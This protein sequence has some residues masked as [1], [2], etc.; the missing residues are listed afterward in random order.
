[1]ILK[2]PVLP[3]LSLALLLAAPL[4]GQQV[5]ELYVFPDTMRLDPGGRGGLTVQ[6]FDQS[7]NAVLA[8]RYR[9]LD[10]LVAR[11]A[12]TGVVTGGNRGSTRVVVEAGSRTRAV[13]VVVAPPSDVPVTSAS[14]PEPGSGSTGPIPAAVGLNRRRLSLSPG[15]R[16]TLVLVALEESNRR[17]AP[18]LAVWSSTDGQVVEVDAA[19]AVSALAVGRAEVVVGVGTTQL[20]VPV[21]V[22]QPVAWFGVSPALDDTVQ[23]PLGTSRE[24]TVLP[25]TADS[26]PI[27]GVSL[28]WSVGDT[29][30]A[31]L[32]PA[33][34]Q[35][36]GLSPGRT[37]LAFQAQ[38]FLAKR[39]NIKVLSGKIAIAVGRVTLSPG[40]RDT[41]RAEH[42]D[43]A[44]RRM[45]RA[46][47]V[48]SSS[49][50][51]VARVSPA[52]VLEA[53]GPGRGQVTARTLSGAAA[54]ATVVVT[55]DLLVAFNRGGR[56]ALYALV[57][58]R[59][60]HPAPVVADSFANALDG[61][62]S[63]DRT[64]LAFS[65]DR[66]GAGN[67]D[68]FLADADGHN[69][70]RLTTDP[71]VDA[72]AVWVPDGRRL[73]YVSR[74]GAIRQLYVVETDGSGIRQLTSLPG[75]AFDPAISPDGVTV[76]FAG[77][78]A[79]PDGRPDLYTVP[80]AGGDPVPATQTPGVSETHPAYLADGTLVWLETSGDA[81][82]RVVRGGA[83]GSLLVP[84][85][86]VVDLAVSPRG[87][88]A[89]VERV[90]PGE[91]REAAAV[92]LHWQT[93]GGEVTVKANPGERIVSPAF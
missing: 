68:L 17:L 31:R 78:S 70:V 14:A 36:T 23:I 8:V 32:D 91:G 66:F 92:T 4:P 26:L 41:L 40:G 44:G 20:R 83:A 39:W 67:Y 76:V 9:V 81:S 10:T 24:F 62:Y 90:M 48:W 33:T 51:A 73:V 89:W 79:G 11:V 19:G 16:D 29:T 93:P 5:T 80:L 71:A 27:E 53:V 30:V 2:R 72:S 75:G 1:M 84:P 21:S 77:L 6:A 46:A 61:R 52:G 85:Q 35:L 74:H 56:F 15:N 82:T 47:V 63:P 65:S 54:T 28:Q 60:E 86:F 42:V 43:D 12:S 7:G 37:T 49:D 13:T 50:A 3:C 45:G 38:G 69:P 87:E 64:R 58:D 25:H 55:G 34:G 59:A 88:L 22:H 18:G 57:A